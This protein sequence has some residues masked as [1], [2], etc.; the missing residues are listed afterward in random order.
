MAPL[1]LSGRVIQG[2]AAAVLLAAVSAGAADAT[3][4]QAPKV[5]W[6]PCATSDLTRQHFACGVLMVPENWDTRQGRT[7]S[8]P[9][10]IRRAAHRHD[11]AVAFL[12][13][14]PGG[15]N[16]GFSSLIAKSF[17]T[18]DRDIVFLERRGA[19]FSEPGLFCPP[20]VKADDQ[21]NPPAV[22]ACAAK[23]KAQGVDLDAYGTRAGAL[24]LE[25]LRK[26]IG[27]GQWDI[28]GASYG[29][30]QAL[31][32][33]RQNPA[34]VRAVVLDSPYP[35]DVD[36]FAESPANHLAA[37]DRVL[38]ACAAD[39]TCAKAFPGLRQT[40]LDTLADLDRR[41]I[42]FQGMKIGGG[43]FL[44]L[45][46]DTLADTSALPKVP[47]IISLIHDRRIDQVF[48][49]LTPQAPAA[50]TVALVP[51]E[52]L[53]AN[54]LWLS[55]ECAERAAFAGPVKPPA[56]ARWPV[57]T[58][59]GFAVEWG[60]DARTACASWPVKPQPAAR[61]PVASA[62]PT[63]IFAGEF[64]PVTPTAWGEHAALTLSHSRVLVVPG[65]GHTV[66]QEPCPMSIVNALY[67]HPDAAPDTACLSAP[68]AAFLLKAP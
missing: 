18:V 10:S 45:L 58:I 64:D 59:K 36:P 16:V 27:V 51:P 56:G 12:I 2:A 19:G 63:L 26:L 22:A 44:H 32:V 33:V 38:D 53:R 39:A 8:L 40:L 23:L 14:G 15:T 31:E 28:F 57:D 29:T 17:A 4:A 1:S 68:R 30:R 11:D 7:I 42:E 35:P 60:G 20:E 49:L 52:K 37:L 25:A 61:A 47:L 41:P 21:W 3:E 43:L 66:A 65:M 34:S 5:T 55:V 13:G 9:F 46:G 54:G 67:E 24:D 62:I 48:A 50:E 6:G